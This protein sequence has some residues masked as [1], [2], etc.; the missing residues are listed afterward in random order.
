MS[1]A[2]TTD[3]SVMAGPMQAVFDAVDGAETVKLV[4]DFVLRRYDIDENA[5]LSKRRQ[6]ALVE[7]RAVFVWAVRH[8]RPETSYPMLGRM[9]GGRD[10]STIISLHRKAVALRLTSPAFETACLDLLALLRRSGG[11]PHACD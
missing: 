9:L 5:L 4:R 11:V 6:R 8:A 2:A 1:A 10:H 3:P 7:A